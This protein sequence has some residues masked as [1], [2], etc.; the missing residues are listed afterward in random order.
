MSRISK[1]DR[2]WKWLKVI[3]LIEDT[4]DIHKLFKAL[5]EQFVLKEK[6]SNI[7]ET[8]E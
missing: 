3:H 6:K 8:K 7:K 4:K 1:K 5:D 2:Y